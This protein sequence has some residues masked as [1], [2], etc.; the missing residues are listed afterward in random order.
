MYSGQT[1]N[2]GIMGK[3]SSFDYD[4]E[5]CIFTTTVGAKV[6][7]ARILTGKFSLSQNCLIMQPKS[8]LSQLKF[9]YY[10]LTVLFEYEKS[11]ITAYM[12]P[13]LRIS[14]LSTYCFYP[15]RRKTSPF[16]GRI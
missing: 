13:S 16:R 14:D 6:M 15:T 10:V 4:V 3:I 8:N 7:S 11:L 9:I 2:N 1:E 5:Q 12:Q